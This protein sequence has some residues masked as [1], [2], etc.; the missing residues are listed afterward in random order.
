MNLKNLL[1]IGLASTTLS[2][3]TN[4]EPY[5]RSFLAKDE[6]QLDPDYLGT[7]FRRHMYFAREATPGGYGPESSGCGCN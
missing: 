7:K 3:C 1:L 6:M 5:E 2:G 4:V